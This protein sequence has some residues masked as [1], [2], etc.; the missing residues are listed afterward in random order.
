M[1]VSPGA[2]SR[3]RDFSLYAPQLGTSVFAVVGTATKG[4]FDELTLITDEGS[5][6]ATFGRA[7]VAHLGLMSAVH[8]LRRGRQLYFIRVGT[9]Y[10]SLPLLAREVQDTGSL[11]TAITITPTSPG[12]WVNALSVSITAGTVAGTYRITITE[13]VA[14]IAYTVDRYDNLLLGAVNTASANYIET[15]INGISDYISVSD[16]EAYTTLNV[17][18]YAFP[19]GTDGDPADNS[20][21][22]GSAGAPPVVPATGLQLL[23]NPE[24]L[25]V[26]IVAVPGEYD[27]TVIA[28]CI[29]L[30]ETRGD[31]MYLA[32]VPQGK[33][34]Q[35]AMDWHNGTGGGAGEPTAALNSS[36]AA[37]YYPWVQVYDGASDSD[38][39][40]P[41]EGLVAAVMAYT[42]YIAE[43]WFA[44]AG[45]NRARLFEVLDIEHS[46]TQGERDQMYSYGNSINPI[47]DF[48]GQ[49]HVIWGQRTLQRAP[50][51]LDRINVRRLLLYLEKVIATSVRYLVMEPND[52]A[53]WQRF[54][55]LIDPLLRAVKSRRGLTDYRIICDETTNTPDRIARN[56][57]LG[58]ILLQPTRTA[59]MITID[60]VLL[61]SGASFEEF[62]AL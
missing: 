3:E 5:L 28:A 60:F 14:G 25:D 51:A 61:P 23:A 21:I 37:L 31:C 12:S 41:A 8:Y 6:T 36:Y 44:P 26:N 45:L 57:M 56:E 29:T 43:P 34:V 13:T 16:T 52:P 15:R 58:K 59:E 11:G 33:T 20:D 53:T 27:R 4:P 32:T 40:V 35:Q 39:W 30:C 18:T 48:R 38:V 62:A 22:I 1:I 47:V 17:G 55:N 9:Y 2:Y 24:T 7:S 54:I 10:V 19:V 49:G 50:T 46:A 42:D